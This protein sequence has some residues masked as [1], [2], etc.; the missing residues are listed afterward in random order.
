M[1][2]RRRA[3][4]AFA[5]AWICLPAAGPVLAGDEEGCLFCHR[6][7]LRAAD[8]SPDGRDLRIW[9][10]PGGPHGALYCSDCHPDAGKAPHAANPGPAQCI[11]ECHGQSATAKESH[12][13]ASFG[14]LIEAHRG[15]ASPGT[16]C[17]L[18]H[19]ASDKAGGRGLI[20]VRC[21]G[22]HEGARESVAR[23]V[24]ARIGGRRGAGMCP[25]CHA[26]HPA[27]TAGGKV[28]CAGP[29]CHAS[30]TVGMKRLALHAGGGA[31][32]R[33]PR[34]AAEGGIVIGFAVLGFF[35]GRR[36]SPPGNGEGGPG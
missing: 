17:R 16:P 33:V 35:V 32:A 13:R 28:S 31:Q 1:W 27:A 21:A 11:G 12:R 15:L 7:E 2:N 18:C 22:C 6:L 23:G 24:H 25:D 8:P 4:I 9:E 30:V 14:G 5:L 19:R 3:G 20:V 34:R 26:V 36:L 10:T 29:G